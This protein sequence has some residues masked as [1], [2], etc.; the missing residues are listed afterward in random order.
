MY[1]PPSRV[2]VELLKINFAKGSEKYMLLEE[3]IKKTTLGVIKEEEEEEELVEDWL[4][5]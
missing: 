1:C 2:R 5:I 4:K 3:S